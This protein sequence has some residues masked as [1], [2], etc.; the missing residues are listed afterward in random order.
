MTRFLT[1]FLC[2]QWFTSL[3]YNDTNSAQGQDGTWDLSELS[4]AVVSD[5]KP[6]NDIIVY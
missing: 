3:Y 5:K 6:D 1:I 4:A 2:C